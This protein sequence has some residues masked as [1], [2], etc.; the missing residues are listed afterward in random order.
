MA[1]K[2][3]DKVGLHNYSFVV[4]NMEMYEKNSPLRCNLFQ[5]NVTIFLFKNT[6]TG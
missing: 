4:K 3:P 6:V 1:Q 2:N 5:K